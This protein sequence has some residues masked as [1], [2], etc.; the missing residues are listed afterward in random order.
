MPHTQPTGEWTAAATDAA[1]DTHQL[2]RELQ[3]APRELVDWEASCLKNIAD[4]LD[5]LDKARVRWESLGNDL[6]EA[7]SRLARVQEERDLLAESHADAEKARE[8][9]RQAREELEEVRCE[10]DGTA[11]E[12]AA[13]REQLEGQMTGQQDLAV[14]RA[15]NEALEQ[16]LME[17]KNE[18]EDW[19]RRYAEVEGNEAEF[20]R[21]MER[22]DEELAD[23][24]GRLV[25]SDLAVE[26]ARE[27][28]AAAERA[29]EEAG[30][31]VQL[32]ANLQRSQDKL[33]QVEKDHAD[34]LVV[35][36]DLKTR[37][38]RLEEKLDEAQKHERKRVRKI[39]DKI[40]GALDDVGAPRG[41]DLSYSE[42][43]RR[44]AAKLQ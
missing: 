24:K 16:R 39:L 40:H 23:A 26:D 29:L 37:S 32:E 14:L 10:R 7:Q 44:L 8:E 5:S 31:S 34:N 13:M 1:P 9:A 15:E 33:A 6:K 25:E 21:L 28:Q 12:L 36:F 3:D 30:D 41:G 11:G 2:R 17:R 18:I 42:R 27:K 20:R 4:L 35:L 43:I 22:R 38:A 19:Q